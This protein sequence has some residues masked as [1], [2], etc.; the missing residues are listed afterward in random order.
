MKGAAV[1]LLV[2]CLAYSHMEV[3]GQESEGK[4]QCIFTDIGLLDCKLLNSLEAAVFNIQ[5]GIACI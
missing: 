4:N 3:E 5:L 1:F 2:S